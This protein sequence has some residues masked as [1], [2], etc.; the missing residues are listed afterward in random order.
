[1]DEG[2]EEGFLDDIMGILLILDD[3]H[4]QVMQQRIRYFYQRTACVLVPGQGLFYQTLYIMIE[5][6]SLLLI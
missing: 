1:M 6:H 3:A 5:G 2:L 4:R